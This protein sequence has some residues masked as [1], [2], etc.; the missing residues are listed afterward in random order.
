MRMNLLRME[1]LDYIYIHPMIQF[2]IEIPS[3]DTV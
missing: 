2:S 3:V 1:L